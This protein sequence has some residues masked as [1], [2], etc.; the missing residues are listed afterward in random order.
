MYSFNGTFLFK[1]GKFHNN[2]AN[3]RA[4]ALYAWTNSLVDIKNCTFVKN[5]VNDSTAS[6]VFIFRATV[7]LSEHNYLMQNK[8]SLHFVYSDVSLSGSTQLS[9]N[10][11]G[12]IVSVAS[13]IVV[14][15]QSSILISENRA[16]DGG[17][18]YLM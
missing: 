14:E 5:K 1:K 3:R 16:T 11:G 10:Y 8:G 15:E 18:I 9:N 6:V 4:A 17:G 13:A 12:A 7:R 2:Q